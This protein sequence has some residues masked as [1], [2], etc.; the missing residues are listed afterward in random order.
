[1]GDPRH[2]AVLERGLGASRLARGAGDACARRPRSGMQ[3][4]GRALAGG[5]VRQDSPGRSRM[6]ATRS[7]GAPSGTE[8]A[9]PRATGRLRVVHTPGHAPDHACL[10]DETEGVLFLRGIC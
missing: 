6:P 8:T 3:G 1:M 2:V 9:W 4:A 7:T 10:F 5:R